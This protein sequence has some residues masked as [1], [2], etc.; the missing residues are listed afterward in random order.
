MSTLRISSAPLL[1]RIQQARAAQK[2]WQQTPIAARLRPIRTLRRQLV[3]ACPRLCAAVG[4][5]LGKPA[6]ETL[7]AEVLPLAEALLFLE[8]QATRLLRPRRVPHGLRPVWLWGQ[9][10]TVYHRPRGLVGIIGTWNY[11]LFLNGVPIAQALT[12]GNAVLWK[13]SEVAPACALALM[14]LIEQAGFPSGLLQRL[15]ATRAAGQELLTLPIDHVVFTGSV[16]TGRRVAVALGERLISST[17]ELSGCDAAIVL[18]DADLGL[19]SRALWFGAMVNRGQTC[20]AARRAFVQRRIYADFCAA[21]KPLAASARPQALALAAQADQAR[22]LVRQALAAKA[23]LLDS[24]TFLDGA[25]NEFAPTVVLDARPEMDLC[26]EAS[27]APLLAVLPFESV[28]DLLDMDAQCRFGLGASLFTRTPRR[29]EEL[30]ARL[31]TGIVAINDV[32]VS[33]AHPATPFGGRGDSGWGVTQGAEGLL[34]MT[35]PQ[36]VSHR[37]GTFRPHYDLTGPQGAAGQAEL[38]Q[39]LLESAHAP[40]WGQ[41][42]RGWWRLLRALRRG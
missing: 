18:E 1:E 22:R 13:P 32:V 38:L 19:A 34:E 9:S 16:S 35:V 28:E 6:E 26:R 27:F 37:S 14:E 12:A 40:T 2:A 3:E 39:G 23:H 21:L 8:R 20:V 24:K 30:A 17:L 25:A 31:R 41:R 29:G 10:D 36:V 11:P 4:R 33:M 15:E 5:E 42:L 7:A